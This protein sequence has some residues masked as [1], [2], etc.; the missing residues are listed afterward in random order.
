MGFIRLLTH[1]YTNVLTLHSRIYTNLSLTP[2]PHSLAG[3]HA[4]PTAPPTAPAH[5]ASSPSP[6]ATPAVYKRPRGDVVVYLEMKEKGGG[7]PPLAGVRLGC[8][9]VGIWG[10]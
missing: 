1:R 10:E 9:R 5:P 4:P 2:H 8:C 3:D 6:L 7:A